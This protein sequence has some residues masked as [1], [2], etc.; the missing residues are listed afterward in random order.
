MQQS[1]LDKIK[2]GEQVSVTDFKSLELPAKFYEL[3][4]FPGSIVEVKYKAPFNGPICLKI[5][6]NDT[7]IAIRKSEAKLIITKAI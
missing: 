1:S 4:F 6:D 5:I 7:L 2:I 3:G